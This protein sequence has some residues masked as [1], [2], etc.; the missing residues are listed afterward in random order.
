M[1]T[2]VMAINS[3]SSSLK[4]Q[5]FEMPE[6]RV[7]LKGLFERIG[8]KNA[9]FTV[10]IKE[11]KKVQTLEVASH[12]TAVNQ[13]LT[14]LVESGVIETIRDIKAIGHRVAHGGEYFSSSVIIDEE[15]LGYI[16]EL[17]ELAPL[18]N[19]VNIIGIKAFQAVLPDSKQVAVFDTAF[20][21]TIS[22]EKFLYPLPTKF[23]SDYKVRKYGFHG[24]SHQYVA[25]KAEELLQEKNQKII[26]CH[27]GNGASI[28]AIRDGKSVN[29]SMGFTPT[30]GL[31]MGTRSGDLDPTILPYLQEKLSLTTK[32]IMHIINSESGLL[33]VSNLSNDIRDIE[34]KALE[35]DEASI[36][37]L[38]MFVDKICHHICEYIVDL[39]G[40][41]TIIFTAGIGENSR[42]IRQKIGEKLAC[43]GVEI[44]SLKNER[45][46][47]FIH[48]EQ[49]NIN[50]L[51]IPTNEELVIAKDT[52]RL[53]NH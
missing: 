40:L 4:F 8:S 46:E 13:L 3:G 27:L 47:T 51:V 53:T 24:T 44:D 35:G 18:H 6:E 19:P 26:S 10:C 7:I 15:V 25:Q 50:L 22:K 30:A 34:L 41:D 17:S 20:H 9:I 49:S 48:A 21:Q 42:L 14:Y 37:A 2:L 45:Q 43:I 11:E 32:D 29:T 16:V 38:N 31:M 23:Y 33:G 5:L 12:E 1:T 39:D 36:I 52:F 28:C